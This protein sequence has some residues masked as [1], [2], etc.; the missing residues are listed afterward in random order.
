MRNTEI[1]AELHRIAKLH[2]GI[3]RPVDVVKAARISTSVLH[4]QFEWD[5]SEA[6]QKFRLWQA[7]QLIRVTV[8]YIG[9]KDEQVP[10]RVFVSLTTDRAESGYRATAAVM[11]NVE[12]RAQLLTDALDEMKRFQKKYADLKEL[13]EVFDAM[14]KVSP[15]KT[16]VAA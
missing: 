16:T 2:G 6:A 8:E 7:R 10:T 9:P 1:V 11:S 13:A 14:R 5:D 15:K 12:Y 4:D 3:L